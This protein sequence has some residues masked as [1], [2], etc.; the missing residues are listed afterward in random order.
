MRAATAGLLDT[1]TSNMNDEYKQSISTP[2]PGGFESED[3]DGMGDQMNNNMMFRMMMEYMKKQDKQMKML[4]QKLK[5]NS[6]S[7]SPSNQD[8]IKNKIDK[9]RKNAK[10][11]LEEKHTIILNEINYLK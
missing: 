11:K 3:E 1:P 4:I 7:Q 5:K 6:C 10:T 8:S 2:M 9:F